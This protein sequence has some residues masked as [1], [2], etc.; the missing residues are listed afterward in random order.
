MTFFDPYDWKDIADRIEWALN[1]REE[2]L[3]VQRKTY[4]ELS[5]RTWADVVGE[6]IAILDRISGHEQPSIEGAAV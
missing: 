6:H 2:L 3:E 5:K 4:A 1:H